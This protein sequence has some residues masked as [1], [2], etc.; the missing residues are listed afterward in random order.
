MKFSALYCFVMFT[1]VIK[2]MHPTVVGYALASASLLEENQMDRTC[3]ALIQIP[4]P[5]G[6]SQVAVIWLEPRLWLHPYWGH[7][8]ELLLGLLMSDAHT[9]THIKGKMWWAALD[10]RT[11]HAVSALVATSVKSTRAKQTH[12]VHANTL[13]RKHNNVA[14]ELCFGP[15]CLS[16]L[17]VLRL[18]LLTVGLLTD[19]TP[20]QIQVQ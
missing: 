19:M 1:H 10:G 11:W 6:S 7:S 8:P 3:Y 18:L 9:K 12:T 20:K 17:I 14:A 2:D 16:F 13:T 15:S 5:T 4:T